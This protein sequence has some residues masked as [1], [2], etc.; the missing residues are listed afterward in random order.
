MPLPT[1]KENENRK[2]FIDRCMA[3]A[4]MLEEYDD[5]N[6][7][8]AVCNTQFTNNKK[9]QNEKSNFNEQKTNNPQ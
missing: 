8:F 2:Q 4:T 3:D 9:S 7:R 6:Q 1:P 5:K